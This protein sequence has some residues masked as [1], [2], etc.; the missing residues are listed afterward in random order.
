MS[1][2]DRGSGI[3]KSR[4]AE[5]G[6]HQYN[7]FLCEKVENDWKFLLWRF[8]YSC[9]MDGE[10]WC[11]KILEQIIEYLPYLRVRRKVEF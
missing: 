10:V 3:E 5:I 4:R 6:L 11:N 2:D 1:T 8:I 7:S 9:F